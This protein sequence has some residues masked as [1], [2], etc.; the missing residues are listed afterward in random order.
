MLTG[1]SIFINKVRQKD[2]LMMKVTTMM[3]YVN[4]ANCDSYYELVIH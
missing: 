1:N 2:G 3:M 4:D